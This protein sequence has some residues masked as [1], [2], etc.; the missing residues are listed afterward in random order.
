[1]S[2]IA[3]TERK[4]AT[5]APSAAHRWMVCPGSIAMEQ[6][7]PNVSSSYAA[8]GTAAHELAGWCLANDEQP[9]DHL[10]L[11]I[12]TKAEHGNIFVDLTDDEGPHEEN[13]YWPI[14]DDMVEAV[15]VYTDFVRSLLKDH[16]D[17]ELD[18]EQRLDMTHLHPDIFGTGDATVYIESERHLHVC[19]YKHGK[20]VA[21]DAK[22]NPQLLLYGAGAAM[23]FHNRP[24]EKVT[25]HIIQPRAPHP[26]GRIRSDPL[27]LFSLFEFEDDI[28]TSA[29]LVDAATRDFGAA[30]GVDGRI[31][32]STWPTV[33]L[34]AGEHCG[35]CRAHA[36]CPTARAAAL[37]LAQAEFSDTGEM[38]LPDFTQM[39]P[40]QMATYMAQA[41]QVVAHFAA[42]KV[43]AHA[44]A[45]AG[46]MPS[47]MKLVAKRATRKWRDADAVVDDLM[48][49]GLGKA[50]LYTEKLKSPAQVEKVMKKKAFEKWVAD[51]TDEDGVGPVVSQSSGTNLVPV[52]DPR[53]AV[54]ADAASDFDAVE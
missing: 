17:A 42:F 12:D 44:E 32:N 43:Y 33:Y 46:R 19:D 41:E 5:L 4:H 9:E 39:D 18:V 49:A 14:D 53:P 37:E 35:F 7:F 27:D 52:N 54:K 31:D 25:L 11:W 1:M 20:G 6:P 23:R 45:C 48:I 21:V 10:G 28:K 50:D 26:K 36:I 8:Q 30:T 16:K 15:T 51:G 34:K 3:H 40:D 47:G 13:R 24:L 29:A 22:N 38:T 2:T